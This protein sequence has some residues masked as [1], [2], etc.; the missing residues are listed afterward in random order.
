MATIQFSNGQSVQF[1]GTPTQADVEEVA[2]HLNIHQPAAAPPAPQLASGPAGDFASNALRTVAE[3][4]IRTGG[5]IEKGL[6]QT[7][8][9]V[10]NA[11]RGKG[12]VPTHTGDAAMAAADASSQDHA[13]TIA[14]HIGDFV[15]TVAPYFT[16]VGE[17]ELASTVSQA[18]AK[19]AASFA[20]NAGIATAQTGNPIQGIETGIGGEALGLAGKATSI[21]GKQAYKALAIPTSKVE[22]KLLQTYRANTPFV[23]RVGAV[24]SGDTKGPVT[25]DETAFAKGLFG[26]EQDIG[27]Q[28]KR[29]SDKL[30]SDGIAPALERSGATID[31]QKFLAGVG[32]QIVKD[33][34][35]LSRQKSLTEALDALKQDYAGVGNVPLKQL[36]D[37]KA[38]WARKVPQKAYQGKDIA[39]AFSEVANVAAQKARKV[40]YKALGPEMR[41]AY[42][43]H[44]NLQSLAEWGQT[45]MTGG[46]FKGG[47]GGFLNALKDAVLTPVATIGGHLL[48]K[49]GNG[50]QFVGPV[51]A[52]YL[53]DLFNEASQH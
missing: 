53:S 25:A 10:G 39:G 8:G 45:A 37:F 36:Q 22:A 23:Q 50:I 7:L 16:G 47:T 14:G 41:R 2:R 42:L 21:I 28:A 13:S 34:P 30:W 12:F 52:R 33:N 20:T 48:Y 38:G 6:D 24:L 3:P 32:K 40:I 44:G 19:H 29:A 51:G 5:L 27:V 26:R 35:E 11:I 4:L 9:R 17:G 49:T 31:M 15:G 1:S 43:D 18:L 46:K